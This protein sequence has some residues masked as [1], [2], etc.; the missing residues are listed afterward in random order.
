MWPD[1]MTH[2]CCYARAA[3]MRSIENAC[4]FRAGSIREDVL[5]GRRVLPPDVLLGS[6][7]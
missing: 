7:G 3:D 6:L 5:C 4:L 2:Q 1:K